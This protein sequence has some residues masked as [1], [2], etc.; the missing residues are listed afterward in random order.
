LKNNVTQDYFSEYQDYP[1]WVDLVP[2]DTSNLGLSKQ[3][4]EGTVADDQDDFFALPP[5]WVYTG[6][7]VSS[8]YVNGLKLRESSY[9]IDSVAERI[10]F[11]SALDAADEIEI[12]S[13]VVNE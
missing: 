13:L 12:V 8:V 5:N 1:V 2:I 7:V 11:S 4:T 3:Q 6:V 9:S 10:I